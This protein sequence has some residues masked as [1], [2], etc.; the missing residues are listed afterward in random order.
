M[1]RPTRVWG[2]K[3]RGTLGGLA[4]AWRV[5]P[6]VCRQG[7]P[8][9]RLGQGPG[10]GRARHGGDR[11]NGRGA[12]SGRLWGRVGNQSRGVGR[13]RRLVREP[14]RKTAWRRFSAASAAAVER[15]WASMAAT[16]AWHSSSSVWAVVR[17]PWRTESLEIRGTATRSCSAV[18]R[19]IAWRSGS[20]AAEASVD[21]RV[22]ASL[23]PTLRRETRPT[24]ARC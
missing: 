24:S 9:A 20:V 19:S 13:R 18:P 22:W 5:V 7:L 15:S 4:V 11:G 23:P 6:E 8:E 2:S 21:S 17:W 14:R 3:C 10:A 16:R 1:P 12:H